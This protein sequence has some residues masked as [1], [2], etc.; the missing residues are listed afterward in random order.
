MIGA[1]ILSIKDCDE[2]RGAVRN[3][4]RSGGGLQN[5][6][7]KPG[8]TVAFI[9]SRSS[10][11]KALSSHTP[12]ESHRSHDLRRA[13]APSPDLGSCLPRGSIDMVTLRPP[14]FCCDRSYPTAGYSSKE[15]RLPNKFWSLRPGARHTFASPGMEQFRHGRPASHRADPLS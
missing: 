8:W 1:A 7:V 15:Y 14:R 9:I 12:E 11:G 6:P 4:C 13:E 5:A 3:R 10:G 2:R